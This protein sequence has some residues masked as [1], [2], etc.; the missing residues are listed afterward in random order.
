MCWWWE[1]KDKVL[2]IMPDTIKTPVI[3][4]VALSKAETEYNLYSQ[5]DPRWSNLKI[6]KTNL[7]LGSHGCLI[8]SLAMILKRPPYEILQEL[9]ESV[10]FTDKTHP[11]GEGLLDWWRASS[12]LKFGYRYVKKTDSNRICIAETNYWRNKGVPQH[13]FVRLNVDT[14]ADPLD[15]PVIERLCNYNI[16]SYRIIDV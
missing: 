16:V 4:D 12:V 2:E 10:A 14:I 13:F 11:K 9:N 5:K 8:C 6:G 3:E 15:Y 7:T 1:K